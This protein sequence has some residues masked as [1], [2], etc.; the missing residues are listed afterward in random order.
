LSKITWTGPLGEVVQVP[1]T[2]VN[3]T[4]VNKLFKQIVKGKHK[5]NLAVVL[6]IQK[7]QKGASKALANVSIQRTTNISLIEA[8]LT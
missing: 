1:I 8:K 3:I 4:Q 7:L 5:L 2:P 6:Q